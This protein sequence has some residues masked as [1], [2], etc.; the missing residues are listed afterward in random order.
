MIAT[1]DAVSSEPSA[2]PHSTRGQR[3]IIGAAIALFAVASAYLALVIITRVDS[4]F[5]PGNELKLSGVP[6]VQHAPLPG[7]DKEGTSGSDEPINILVVG[8]DRRPREGE[9]PTRTDTIFVVHVDPKRK[10]STILGF[11]RDLVVEV[12]ADGGGTYKDRINAAY[13]TGELNDYPGGGVGLMKEVFFLNFD[14]KIDKY[15]LIDFDGFEE[16]IDALGGIDVEV[17]EE[18]YDPYY[19]HTE[20]PGDY[21]PQYFDVGVHHMDGETALAYA[22]IRFSGDDLDR[23]HRQQ[24]VIFAAIEKAKTL[25]LFDVGKTR[26]LWSKYRD[27]IKTDV[28]DL[29]V[30][31]YAL[32]ADQLKDSLEAVSLGPATVPCTGPGGAAWLCWDEDAVGA[33][34]EAVF[35]ARESNVSAR[36]TVTPDPV[37]VQVENGTGAEGLAARVVRY[38]A[39]QG[40]PVDDLNAANATDGT[41]HEESVIIDVDGSHEQNRLLLARWLNIDLNNVR[42]ATADERAAYNGTADIV[43]IL[44]TDVDYDTLIEANIGTTEGG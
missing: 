27:T 22:R 31:G 12:P 1:L 34:V 13:V 21:A 14:I 30:P 40:Y 15:V 10:T 23:I 39:A 3:I 24:Q 38:I 32:L 4:L 6:I 17:T 33:I 28:S 16:L 43:V 9:E 29:E 37:R 42:V 5:F 2:R 36:P 44:G 8:L 19:S 18:V 20:L 11:P 26:D 35:Y 41:T 7:V 25:N